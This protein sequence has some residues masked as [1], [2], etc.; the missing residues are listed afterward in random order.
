M[1]FLTTS[2]HIV[3]AAV[4]SV[5]TDAFVVPQESRTLHATDSISQQPLLNPLPNHRSRTNSILYQKSDDEEADE[6]RPGSRSKS[7]LDGVDEVAAEAEEALKAA[8]IALQKLD[9]TKNPGAADQLI[10]VDQVANDNEKETQKIISKLASGKLAAEDVTTKLIAKQNDIEEVKRREASAQEKKRRD[11][12]ALEA[13]QKADSLKMD[14]FK[15][16]FGATAL[17]VITGAALDVYFMISDIDVGVAVPPLALGISLGAAAFVVGSKEDE[18]GQTVRN[19][20]AGAVTSVSD[21][22]TSSVTNAVDSAVDNVKA[23]PDNI[24]S[25]VDDKVKKTTKEIQQIPDRVKGAAIETAEGITGEIK[26]IPDRVKDA[27]IETADKTKSE[28]EI[29]A[30][31]AVE[32]VKATPGRVAKGTKEA[33][34][35]TVEDVEGKIEKAVEDTVVSF[36]GAVDEVVALPGKTLDDVSLRMT[37]FVTHRAD[38][39]DFFVS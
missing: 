12:I 3:L 7:P 13:R 32:E 15:S 11:A 27:A 21:S 37:F 26:Q 20:F 14:A 36:T 16:A 2:L 22:V 10:D 17:G 39:I 25:A 24:K 18:A 6:K 1:K 4:H 23:I 28:I 34:V 8:E 29:A 19:I 9:L 38:L 31:K 5:P 35:K 30:K 33:V